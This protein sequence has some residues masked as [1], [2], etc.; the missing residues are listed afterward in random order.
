MYILCRTQV[1]LSLIY[2]YCGPCILRPP[3]QAEKYSLKL[4]VALKVGLFMM[5]PTP[6]LKIEQILKWRDLKSQ[7]P[8]YRNTNIY[9]NNIIIIL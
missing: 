5:S 4:K 6:H 1:D 7:A 2:M 8:L 9:I 3:I